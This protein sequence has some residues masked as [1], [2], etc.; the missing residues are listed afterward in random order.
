MTY[1]LKWREYYSYARALLLDNDKLIEDT[2][3]AR[4]PWLAINIHRNDKLIEDRCSPA[5][6]L[7]CLSD[8]WGPK[9]S[10][11]SEVTSIRRI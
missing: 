7:V 1:N 2:A 6:P 3:T 10:V 11:N 5:P 8:S 9:V 4:Q